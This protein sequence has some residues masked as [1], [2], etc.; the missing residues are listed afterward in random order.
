MVPLAYLSSFVVRNA[1][2]ENAPELRLT[3]PRFAG[4]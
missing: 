1:S 4:R 2:G 3:E